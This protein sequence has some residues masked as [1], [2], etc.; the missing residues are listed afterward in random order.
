MKKF[1][2]EQLEEAIEKK[3]RAQRKKTKKEGES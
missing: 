1:L 2:L 3:G